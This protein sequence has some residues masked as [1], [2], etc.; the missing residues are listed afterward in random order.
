[1]IPKRMIQYETYE[2]FSRTTIWRKNKNKS[3]SKFM[4]V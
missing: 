2:V 1:M 3:K 4:K